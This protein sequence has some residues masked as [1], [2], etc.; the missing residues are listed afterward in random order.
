MQKYLR[1]G[2]STECHTSRIEEKGKKSCKD[3]L[4]MSTGH[5]CR[6][7]ITTSSAYTKKRSN[8]VSWFRDGAPCSEMERDVSV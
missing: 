6:I 4:P 5:I 2:K 7:M 3:W 8:F 1:D